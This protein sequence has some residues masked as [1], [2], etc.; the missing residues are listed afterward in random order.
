[1]RKK[2]FL[3]SLRFPYYLSICA[4]ALTLAMNAQRDAYVDFSAD[5]NKLFGVIDNPRTEI[6]HR[7]LDFDFEI[8][9][10]SKNIGIFILYGRFEDADY[11]NYGMGADYYF[12]K[13]ESFDISVGGAISNVMRKQ[14]F[15]EERNPHWGTSIGW[16]PRV[17]GTYWVIP[18]FGLSGRFQYQRRPDI[19][20]HGIL[21]GSLGIM[22]KFAE[23]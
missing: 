2:Y 21:E 13:G 20:I 8:G 6:D 11:Q 3:S 17:K 16:A 19:A 10:R 23:K 12:A 7:G 18:K 5:G 15:G 4:M 14:Y 1:M 9:A 22:F